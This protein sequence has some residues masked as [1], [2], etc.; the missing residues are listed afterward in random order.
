MTV[1]NSAQKVERRPGK[2]AEKIKTK[3]WKEQPCDDNPFISQGARCYG[4]D[5]LELAENVSLS[6]GLYLLF[7]G[8]LP[9][10]H[11]S[12]IFNQLSVILMNPG[13]RH[14]ACRAAMNAGVGKT[15]ASHILPIGLT[16]LGGERGTEEVV[17]A[18]RFLNKNVKHDPE[19]VFTVSDQPEFIPGFGLLYGGVDVQTYTYLNYLCESSEGSA[20]MQ[21]CLKYCELAYENNYGITREGMAAA[22]FCDLGFLPK[23]GGALYQL[24]SAPGVLAHG[25]EYASKPFSDFPFV[26]DE[27][28]VIEK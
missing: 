3:I 1:K 14:E 23:M 17:R 21:W 18:M 27:N 9:E 11:E 19:K 5:L 15:E 26:D 4:Y 12:K 10:S 13:P 6:D 7:R 16:L 8:R 22:A 20:A 25:L 28:Y 24:L 2:F